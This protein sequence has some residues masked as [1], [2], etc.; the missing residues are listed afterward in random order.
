LISNDLSTNQIKESNEHVL[1]S[2]GF[3]KPN[4]V[5]LKNSKIYDDQEDKEDDELYQK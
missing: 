5:V 4:D 1:S 2:F 3:V